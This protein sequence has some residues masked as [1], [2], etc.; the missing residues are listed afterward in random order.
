APRGPFSP[1]LVSSA[2]ATHFGPR[3]RAERSTSRGEESTPAAFGVQSG[4]T[5]EGK[6]GGG[7]VFPTEHQTTSRPSSLA[8]CRRFPGEMNS[9]TG[10]CRAFRSVFGWDWELPR[11]SGSFVRLHRPWEPCKSRFLT[12]E[13]CHRCPPTPPPRAGRQ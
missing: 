4:W 1:V 6:S 10:A 13:P 9:E 2:R 8:A 7:S 12:L 5:R 3:P 11:A